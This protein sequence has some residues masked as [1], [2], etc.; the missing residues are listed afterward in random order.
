MSNPKPSIGVVDAMTSRRLFGP[1]F[2]GD[3]WNTWRAVLKA[4]FAEPM[5]DAELATFR[6]VAERS[7]PKH[8]VSEAVY[9]IGRSG[10]KDS[11][12]S[13]IASVIAVNFDPR[14][15]LRPGEKAVVMCIAVDRTQAGIVYGY[16]R[17]AFEQTPA[18]AALVKSIDSE[19]FELHSGVVI[20]VH[21]NSYRSVRGRSIIC[22]I[23]DEVAFWRSEDSATPDVEVAGAVSPGLARMSGSMLILI[24]T[25]HRRSGLLYQRWKD[26]YGRDD[27]DVLVVR[28]TTLQFNPT[29][30][31]K[32]ITRQIESDPQL[33]NAEYNSQWR[34]DLSTFISRDLLEAAVDRG[35]VVRPPVAGT[36]YHSFADPSGGAHDS[37]TLAITHREK[38]DSVVLDLLY[39]R[40]APFNPS[41]ATGEIATLLKSYRCTQTTGDRYGAQWVVEAFAKCGITYRTSDRDRS[42]IYL[43]CLP[44]FTSGRCRLIDNQRLVAQFAALE[45][46]TFSTGK[47]RVDHG[48]ETSARDDACN[49]AAGALV[50]ASGT[51][52]Y[53]SSLAWVG[54]PEPSESGGSSFRHPFP[55]MQFVNYG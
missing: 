43:D 34:D 35:V 14:G 4:T 41:E 5:D 23:F 39:E 25:A 37:F 7:P 44:L 13:L 30:D 52:G 19:S 6:S 45:R 2:A 42:A 28:G 8:R 33:Y 17:A 24:S 51:G 47:D 31:A 15:K 55:W 3:S 38:D 40:K 36:N 9:I 27:D 50:L 32:I 26:S 10:G 49:S 29:F 20:E 21:T 11:I 53:D 46:R 12:A 18:L 48:R 22:A 54:A 16:I 1:H